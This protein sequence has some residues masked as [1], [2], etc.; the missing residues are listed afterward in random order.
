M[1]A[2]ARDVLPGGGCVGGVGGRWRGFAPDFHG[3]VVG[4]GSEDVA[5]FGVGLEEGV[6]GSWV[7][8][9]GG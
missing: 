7:R 6:L 3:A 8:G 2:E 5:V 9:R 4:G 1:Q